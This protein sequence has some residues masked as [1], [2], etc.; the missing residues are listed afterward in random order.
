MYK[1][2]YIHLM[3]KYIKII[4]IYA[5]IGTSSH[6]GQKELGLQAVVSHLMCVLAIERLSSAKSNDCS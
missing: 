3:Y 2:I 4:Y 1:Y 5:C 6:R